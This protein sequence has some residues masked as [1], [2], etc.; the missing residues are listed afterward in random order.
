MILKGDKHAVFHHCGFHELSRF[1]ISAALKKAT[2][3][4]HPE[5]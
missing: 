2:I 1:M 3:S 5:S 4:D